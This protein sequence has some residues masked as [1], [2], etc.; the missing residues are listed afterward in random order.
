ME[1]RVGKTYRAGNVALWAWGISVSLHILV[2]A[3][4]CLIKSADKPASLSTKALA[5]LRVSQI[6]NLIEAAPV[7][8]KSQITRVAKTKPTQRTKQAM[9]ESS[10][11]LG[12][13]SLGDLP[14]L[15]GAKSSGIAAELAESKLL[16]DR[17]DV[18][19]NCSKTR[20]VCFVV[21]CSGSMQG[22]LGRVLSKLTDFVRQLQAD[23][24]F[25]ILV[26][27]ADSIYQSGD[28][29]LV[30]ASEKAKQQ[31]YHFMSNIRPGGRTNA[32]SAL[33]KAMRLRDCNGKA[34]TV[35]YFLTDGFE[36]ATEESGQFARRVSQLRMRL[37]SNAKINVIAFWP[38][39]RDRRTLQA[40]ARQNDGQITIVRQ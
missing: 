29:Q 38:R 2:L 22:I 24:Y 6:S 23:E 1:R 27:G 9:F 15:S 11:I 7:I 16:V 17:V 39:N 8:P 18:L 28:G 34:A 14:H 36:F 31:A 5:Q 26:F 33:E 32:I 40:I 4:L 35:I 25:S 21:D 3:A 19:D 37:A 10:K 13:E 30:R 20:R 12:C